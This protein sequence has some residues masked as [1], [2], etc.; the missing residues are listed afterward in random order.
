MILFKSL[1]L[2]LDNF[3]KNKNA[4]YISISSLFYK[5]VNTS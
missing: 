4:A 5:M 1:F 3:K 2:N